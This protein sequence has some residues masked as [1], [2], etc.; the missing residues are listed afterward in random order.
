M[1]ILEKLQKRLQEGKKDNKGFSLVELIIVIAIMAILI[2][3]VG[4]NVIPQIEN[5]RKATDAQVISALVTEAMEAWT[6]VDAAAVA[7]KY[8]I[9][10]STAGKLSYD[11]A[12][13]SVN[14]GFKNAFE[15]LAKLADRELKS[16]AGKELGS[17]TINCDAANGVY[18]G[19]ISGTTYTPPTGFDGYEFRSR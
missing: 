11:S 10:V 16:K 1:K 14:D 4:M 6:Q 3:I 15:A 2:G 17:I 13:S 7:E 12:N 19:T 18:I 8:T 9:T 5:A